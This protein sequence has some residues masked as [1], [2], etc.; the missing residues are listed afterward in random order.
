MRPIS[1]PCG[2]TPMV[3]V[4]MSPCCRLSWLCCSE[5]ELD[6][7]SFAE[8]PVFPCSH[9]LELFAR[10]Q[11]IMLYY[12][13]GERRKAKFKKRERER[14][15]ILWTCCSQ[16]SPIRTVPSAWE[17]SYSKIYLLLKE[18]PPSSHY[19]IF[20]TGFNLVRKYLP[21]KEPILPH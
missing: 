7:F 8:L 10:F 21:H 15:N 19:F 2:D 3:M 12:C 9:S 18:K 13:L 17:V 4:G 16:I 6:L 5:G 14:E 11:Q 20:N 1:L